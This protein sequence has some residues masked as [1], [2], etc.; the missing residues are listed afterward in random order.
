MFPSPED[1]GRKVP[2][3]LAALE[4]RP[5]RPPSLEIPGGKGSLFWGPRASRSDYPYCSTP[6]P[7]FWGL[8]GLRGNNSYCTA[9]GASRLWDTCGT[10][11]HKNGQQLPNLD[12]RAGVWSLSCGS[13]LGV[14]ES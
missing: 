10:L 4:S 8:G 9:S 1:R 13:L 2:L 3:P 6:T 5:L 14:A 12:K 11:M 7:S